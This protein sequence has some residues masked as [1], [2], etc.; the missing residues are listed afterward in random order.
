[1]PAS[2]ELDVEAYVILPNLKVTKSQ[3]ATTSKVLESGLLIAGTLLPERTLDLTVRV[4]NPTGKAIE[5]K[6]GVRC[7][8]EEVQL[9]EIEPKTSQPY[10]CAA[11]TELSTEEIHSVLKPLWT[12]ISEDVPD[13]ARE[14][15]K[16]ILLE[17]RSAFSLHEWDLGFTSVLQHEIDTGSETP[18]RQPLRRQPLTLLPVIDEQ[19]ELMLQ[20]GLIE[21]SSSAW[22][23]NVV[24]VRK[25]DG[26]SR[27]CVDYRAVNA[28][29]RKDASPLPLI[30]ECLDT[31]RGTRWFSTFDLRAG[32]HQVAVH[33]RDR[34]KTAFVTRKVS[35]QFRVL[36]FGL[37][38]SPSTFSRMMNLVMAGLN[39]AICLI[40]LDDIIVFAKD[41]DTHVNRLTQVLRRLSAVNLKFKPSKCH[42]L[43]KR[44]LFLGHVISE[45]GVATD[46]GKI[47]AVQS[48]PT[49]QKLRE[50][51]AFLGL[52]SYY[53]KFVADFAQ[54]G[55]PLH[56]L[57]KKGVKFAWTSGSIRKA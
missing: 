12:E 4:M 1:M 43:Q 45:E 11:V 13:E 20:Q 25:R 41:L 23:S 9:M 49:P 3:W 34:H 51:R 48:W 28:K 44:V 30:S 57:A 47:E 2:S 37:T 22:S 52:C 8:L 15:L 6:K 27:F 24:M 53:R 39:F 7:E 10:R 55:R 16:Q 38:N 18:V 36:P 42:L 31:L 56:A 35:F 54:I 26:T 29:T 19:V 32:Y 14:R 21:P 46:L 5:L 33:E 17:N 50:V 40:Y